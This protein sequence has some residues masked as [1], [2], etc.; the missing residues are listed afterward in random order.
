MYPL[1][2]SRC[3]KSGILLDLLH[4]GIENGGFNLCDVGNASVIQAITQN[5]CKVTQN[6]INHSGT[7]NQTSSI[8]IPVIEFIKYDKSH[9]LTNSVHNSDVANDD[10]IALQANIMSLGVFLWRS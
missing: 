4:E 1:S 3:T 6:F 7:S 9:L 10:G 5:V 8:L 2:V